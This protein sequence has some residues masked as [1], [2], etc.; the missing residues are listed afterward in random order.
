MNMNR[1]MNEKWAWIEA[2]Q[3]M[4]SQLLDLLSDADLAFHPG[5]QNMTLV[6]QLA[7]E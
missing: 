1:M 3:G 4:R 2:A 7:I 6:G 5:G